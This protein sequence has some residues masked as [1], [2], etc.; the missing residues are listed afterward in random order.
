MMFNETQK[1]KSRVENGNT[2]ALVSSRRINK[3][4]LTKYAVTPRANASDISALNTQPGLAI[5]HV[6][7]NASLKLAKHTLLNGF[8]TTV[9]S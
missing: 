4:E 8:S 1:L 6:F 2:L 9:Y 3:T 7:E 5:K